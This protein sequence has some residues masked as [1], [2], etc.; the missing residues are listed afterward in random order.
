MYRAEEAGGKHI[1]AGIRTEQ[2]N[3]G[4]SLGLAA[5]RARASS[6]DPSLE[7]MTIEGNMGSIEV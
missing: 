6:A 2:S 3:K 5:A 7:E 4:A 1:S